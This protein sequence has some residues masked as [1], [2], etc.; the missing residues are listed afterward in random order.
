MKWSAYDTEIVI[1]TLKS[2]R[3][4]NYKCHFFNEQVLTVALVSILV[5]A[6]A[7]ALLAEAGNRWLERD[8]WRFGVALGA[9]VLEAEES[10]GDETDDDG[11][12]IRIN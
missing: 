4:N 3:P 6:P 5:T 1:L 11:G 9:H 10:S 7:G 8:G 2:R 12:G